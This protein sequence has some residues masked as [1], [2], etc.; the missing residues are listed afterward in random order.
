MLYVAAAGTLTGKLMAL[1]ASLSALDTAISS[2]IPCVASSGWGSSSDVGS[3]SSRPLQHLMVA[4]Q[5]LAGSWL[6]PLA[7]AAAAATAHHAV[8]SGSDTA[9]VLTHC[10]GNGQ[11]AAEAAATQRTEAAEGAASQAPA[12]QL[13]MAAALRQSAPAAQANTTKQLLQSALQALSAISNSST[14]NTTVAPLLLMTE[15]QAA[16]IQPLLRDAGLDTSSSSQQIRTPWVSLTDTTDNAGSGTSGSMQSSQRTTSAAAAASTRWVYFPIAR[17]AANGVLLL[18]TSA[19]LQVHEGPG[20]VLHLLDLISVTE[21]A[22]Q[23]L[24]YWQEE[25]QQQQQVPA[26]CNGNQQPCHHSVTTEDGGQQVFS[27]QTLSAGADQCQE[28]GCMVVPAQLPLR[29]LRLSSDVLQL[30]LRHH[31]H[32]GVRQQ[33]YISGLQPLLQ[34]QQQVGLAMLECLQPGLI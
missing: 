4:R 11:A 33:V 8:G 34:L 2:S 14:A 13:Q 31:P 17:P 9:G 3:H 26:T 21:Q 23:L 18:Q 32:P 24:Q 29:L 6:P 22:Q 5:L 1:R 7:A 28:G 16:V 30:L 12:V 15:D 10:N 25:Q 27:S 20:G 19:E